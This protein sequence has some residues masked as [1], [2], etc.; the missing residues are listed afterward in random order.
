MD[1][2]QIPMW[3]DLCGIVPFKNIFGKWTDKLGWQHVIYFKINIWVVSVYVSFTE[4]FDSEK[5]FKV[6]IQ[7][8]RKFQITF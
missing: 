1:Q 2:Y 6:S 4:W 3:I 8:E 7:R 5:T